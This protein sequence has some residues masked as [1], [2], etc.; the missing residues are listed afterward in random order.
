MVAVLRCLPHS[1]P[2]VAPTPLPTPIPSNKL[3]GDDELIV[4][5]C[6][7][8]DGLILE[9]VRCKDVIP[10]LLLIMLFLRALHSH[11]SD[12]M[13]QFR[14]R[15]K[16]LETTTI[17][18]IVDDTNHYDTFILKE[19]RHGYKSS[20]PSSRVPAA[21]SAHTD[22][23]GTVWNSPFNWLC[24]S[25]GDKRIKTQ[26]KQ[27]LGGNGICPICHQEEPKHVPKDCGL[28]KAS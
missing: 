27:A 13:E 23:A 20:I 26:W 15:H 8:F 28:L 25:Y 16:S 2:S 1:M 6:S 11:Y 10:P 7:Q 18:F 12:I 19:P 9:M 14:T 3:H 17:D 24:K 4:A 21:A 5:F 22:N